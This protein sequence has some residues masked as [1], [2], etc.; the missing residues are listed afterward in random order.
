MTSARRQ[1][2]RIARGLARRGRGAAA[3]AVTTGDVVRHTIAS[4]PR[5]RLPGVALRAARLVGRRGFGLA[6]AHTLGLLMPDVPESVI[7]DTISKRTM[8]SL[9]ER[10]NPEEFWYPTEDK[11]LFYRLAELQGIRVPALYA[12]LCQS[13]PGWSR[14]GDVIAGPDDWE[15]LLGG[16]LPETF[17]VK[18]ALGH[19]GLGIRILER[20]GG[21]LHDTSGDPVTPAELRRQIE[22]DRRFHIYVVQER[23]T[24]R[25]DVPGPPGVLNTT[26]INTVVR[27]DGTVA[28]VSACHK[29]ATGHAA[30]DNFRLGAT[31]NVSSTVDPETGRIERILGAGPD[32]VLREL[33]DGGADVGGPE[34]GG[35]LPAWEECLDLVTAAAP[36]FLPA[37]TIGWDVAVTPDG[38]VIVEANMWWDP[39]ETSPEFDALQAESA[40]P[41]AGG[42]AGAPRMTGAWTLGATQRIARGV[43][44]RGRAATRTGRRTAE[45]LGTTAS[46]MRPRDLAAVARRAAYLVGRRRFTLDEAFRRGL[47]EPGLPEAELG[48]H[49]SKREML[50]HQKT[51]NPDEFWY[52]TEDKAV[53]GRFAE[54]QGV[55]VPETYAL[56]C[57]SG[58]GWSRTGEVLA[59][60]GDWEA[61]IGDRLPDT[62]VLKPTLGV[63]GMGVRV[64]ERREGR[65]YQLDRGEI[66]AATICEEIVRDRQ[67]HA[68]L[69]QERLTNHPD[70]AGSDRSALQTSRIMTL[71]GRDG[72][73]SL[74]GA[75]HKTALGGEAIDNF[76]LGT[77]G[78]LISII[79]VETG[80][81]QRVLAAGEHGVIGDLAVPADPATPPPGSFVPL[82]R[83]SCDLCVSAARAFLPMRCLG[84]D[85]AATPDGPVIVEANMWWDPLVGAMP[86]FGQGAAAR[87]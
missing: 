50:A 18:P 22:H 47:L 65:L 53:F 45:I 42:P 46:S 43:A 32:G 83:E 72:D 20:R 13:G 61:L 35:R 14:D 82:W 37:R 33:T 58:P 25:P 10:L 6:E 74:L 76:R 11:A 38:P 17:V 60:R 68:Y 54:L 52:L 56:L 27:R 57:Q 16:P 40:A 2:T 1:V 69:I 80:R 15:R 71:V 29:S 36:K 66:T 12:I 9:Q 63:Y 31:G 70:V 49:V 5:S 4:T 77:S 48:D 86:A 55:R 28:A 84:W 62:F 85:V 78:N 87:R 75:F 39:L 19:H 59:D 24:N 64:I 8:V 3:Q 81:I 51:L 73:V 79:D 26:R 41:G 21:A 7:A 44:R 23:L 30:I 34:L 67:F